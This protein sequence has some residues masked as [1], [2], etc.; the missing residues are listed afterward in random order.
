MVYVQLVRAFNKVSRAFNKMML[1]GGKKTYFPKFI[2]SQE[3]FLGAQIV[4]WN[5]DF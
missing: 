5:I 4:P 2:S 3:P 1:Q